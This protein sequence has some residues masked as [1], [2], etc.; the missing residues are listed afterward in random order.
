MQFVNT[1]R[2][3]NLA[4]AS[5]NSSLT[6]QTDEWA[7]LEEAC[8]RRDE[9]DVLDNLHVFKR[10]WK[11]KFDT[12]KRIGLISRIGSFPLR[13]GAS[14]DQNEFSLGTSPLEA[15]P[16][17]TAPSHVAVHSGVEQQWRC[18]RAALL[19]GSLNDGQRLDMLHQAVEN[20]RQTN[21]D[22]TSSTIDLPE[23]DPNTYFAIYRLLEDRPELAFRSHAQK[24]PVFITAAM[25]GAYDLVR[26]MV[27]TMEQQINF[28]L[29]GE[30]LEQKDLEE[31]VKD[32]LFDSLKVSDSASNTALAVAVQ[33]CHSKIVKVLLE[34]DLRLADDRFLKKSHIKTACSRGDVDI[35][36]EVL[37]A[38]PSLKQSLPEIIV[39][40]GSNGYKT[41]NAMNEAFTQDLPNS[42]ILHLAV[43]N[44]QLQIV[45]WLVEKYPDLATHEVDDGAG[46]K[47]ALAYNNE[48]KEHSRNAASIRDAIVPVI[49]RYNTPARIQRL[50]IGAGG[51]FLS[52][53]PRVLRFD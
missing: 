49:V 33:N 51:G 5:S 9:K 43:K 41:W 34:K 23:E 7:R 10:T 28:Q 11:T 21:E 8:R 4:P 16:S 19:L 52:V 20:L 42:N 13:E 36:R 35:I 26:N 53:C 17:P 29:E 40:A 3:G 44:Q 47:I 37:E 15:V 12:K 48:Q 39:Q 22:E 45:E 32:E 6:S 25:F 30:E 38:R 50:L 31:L 46:R 14:D 18:D 24:R 27:E 1:T 2:Q